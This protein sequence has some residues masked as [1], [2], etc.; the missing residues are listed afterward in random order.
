VSFF[1]S[2]FC[3]IF[4]GGYASGKHMHGIRNECFVDSFIDDVILLEKKD[5]WENWGKKCY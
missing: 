2:H 4:E 1:V 3:Q 5:N